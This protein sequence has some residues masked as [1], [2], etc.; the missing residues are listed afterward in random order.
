MKESESFSNLLFSVHGPSRESSLVCFGCYSDLDEH[1]P[2]CCPACGLPLCKESCQSSA[3]HQ[4]ECLAFQGL[5]YREGRDLSMSLLDDTAFLH[6]IVLVLRCL[7]LRGSNFCLWLSLMELES[8]LEMREDSELGARGEKVALWITKYF[9][10]TLEVDLGSLTELCGIL[11]VNSFEVTYPKSSGTIQAVYAEAGCL[12]E[13]NCIPTAH[14]VF[15]EDLS[16][17]LRAAV[18]IPKDEHIS[19]T[20]T[21]SLWP[22]TERRNHLMMTKYFECVCLRC[23]DPSE[24][25]TYISGFKCMKCTVGYILPVDPIDDVIEW[26]CEDCGNQVPSPIIDSLNSQVT[27]T[28]Q[29]LEMSGLTPENCEKFLTVHLRILHPQHAHMLDVKHS[30]LHILGHYEGHLMADLSDKQLQMKEEIARSILQVADRLL[31]GGFTC[32]FLLPCSLSR[33]LSGL[34]RLRGTTL[35]ELFLTHQQRGLNWNKPESQKSP[36]D[37]LSV[38]KV[39]LMKFNPKACFDYDLQTAETYLSQCINA[40]QY[41]PEHQAEG[42]LLIQAKEDYSVLTD[43]IKSLTI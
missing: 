21:D 26:A 12:V 11:D 13:H 20:Y 39:G 14:R 24:L 43:H 42:R 8:H 41:E 35:Y 25:K 9:G 28:L 29:L 4:P 40:L 31:P 37:V 33:S 1:E 15:G 19:I 5:G 7:A 10:P 17:T 38:F 22:T 16:M 23:V 2:V 30:L 3:Q 32:V 18:P 27:E 34:S 6:E 36:K